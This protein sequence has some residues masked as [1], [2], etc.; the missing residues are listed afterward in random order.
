MLLGAAVTAGCAVPLAEGVFSLSWPKADGV[1]TQSR[2]MPGYRAIGVDIGYR[3]ATSGQTY[4]GGRFRFQFA[5]TARHMRSRDVQ[6]ILGRYRVGEPVKIAV[7]PRNPADSVLEPGP[8]I[9]SLVPFAL[10]LF[11]LLLGLGHIR[12][13]QTEPG[14]LG[15]PLPLGRGT[16]WRRSLPSPGLRWRAWAPSTCT[17]GSAAFGGP[18]SRAE[19][20]TP[21]RG[22]GL[23]PRRCFGMN[24]TSITGAT[25]H[26]GTATR[27]TPRPSWMWPSMQPNDTRLDALFRLLQSPRPTRR[28]APG[29]RLVGQLRSACLGAA[30]PRSRVGCQAVRRCHGQS[31]RLVLDRSLRMIDHEHFHRAAGGVQLQPELL[32]QCSKKIR[33]PRNSTEPSNRRD[34]PSTKLGIPRRF[35]PSKRQI[36]IEFAGESRLIQGPAGSVLTRAP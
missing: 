22:P 34:P 26:P 14:L 19:S 20:S 9:D 3:Y 24:T 11:L 15:G 31:E 29:R 32:L 28:A 25:F 27:G 17:R 12:T 6:S 21:T 35:C 8:D 33:D 5:L 18:L 23:T 16:A 10:G 4:S 2:N 7:N 36:E 13:D 30:R 1:I